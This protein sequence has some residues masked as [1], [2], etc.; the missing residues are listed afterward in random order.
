M[1]KNQILT[2]E[3]QIMLMVRLAE[4]MRKIIELIG[5]LKKEVDWREQ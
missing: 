2:K 3:M 4:A 1:D 5:M